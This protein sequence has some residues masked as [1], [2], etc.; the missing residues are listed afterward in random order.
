VVHNSNVGKGVTSLNSNGSTVGVGSTFLD[1]VYQAV[2]VS[3]AQTSTPG[4][5]VTY[6]AKVTASLTSYNG[7]SGIGF[8]NFYGEY[9]WGRI[10]LGS[11]EK[12]ISY[13]A[14][15]IKWIYWNSN[16]YND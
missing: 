1:N 15:T 2:A 13:N 10:A 7:L 16:W 11:R 14:Y 12:E 8:S 5:G 6:V 9:S 4:L 3:I